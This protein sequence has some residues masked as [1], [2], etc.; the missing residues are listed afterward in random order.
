MHA[1]SLVNQLPATLEALDAGRIDAYKA[2][3]I[4]DETGTF[5]GKPELRRRV[6]AE[7]LGVAEHK[8]GPALRAYIRRTI[9][10]LAPEQAEQRRSTAKGG[11]RVSKPFSEHDGMG[12]MVLRGPIHDLAA[13][14]TALDHAARH[15][16]QLA[17]QD[18]SHPDH[19]STLEQLRFDVLADLGYSALSAGHLGCCASDC[20]SVRQRLGTRHGRPAQL[21]VT[22][23]AGALLGFDDQPA[24]LEGFGPISAEVARTLAADAVWRRLL[25]DP[26]SGALLDYGTVTYTP[27]Q[28]LRDHVIARDRTCRWPTCSRPATT[29]QLVHTQPHRPDGTGGATADHNLAPLHDRH[30]NDKTHHGFQFT[31]PEPGRFTITTP[32]GLTYTVDPEIIGPVE[33]PPPQGET[34]PDP[35]VVTDQYADEPDLPDDPAPP[36]DEPPF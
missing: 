24:E 25:T 14:W 31:Q 10:R 8:T 20:A 12:S 16:R 4:D 17:T 30:H 18:P 6:E 33:H 11:R 1:V 5:A 22:V 29:S 35:P 21:N 13:F 23:P 3:I 2:R 15:R 19:D 36:L 27:P 26:A 28:A 9:I 34:S 7:A 32:A